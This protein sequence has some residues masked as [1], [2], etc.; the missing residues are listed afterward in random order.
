M[1]KIPS[2]YKGEQL[3]DA[4]NQLLGIPDGGVN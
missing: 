4:V 1:R 3:A 2:F